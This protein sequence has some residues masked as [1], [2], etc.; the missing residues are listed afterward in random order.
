MASRPKILN[1]L[2]S[3]VVWLLFVLL[4]LLWLPLTALVWLFDR[5]PA[6]Y[7]T[8]RFFRWLAHPIAVLGPSWRARVEGVEIQNPRRPY[9]V[10]A[11][12]QSIL[13][14]PMLALIPMEYKWVAKEPLFRIPV[15]GWMMRLAGDIPLDRAS[16]RSGIQALKAARTY[17]DRKCSV[18]FFPEGTR[19]EDRRVY[20][21]NEGAF[22][23]AVKAQVP[24][25]PMAIEG[26]SDCLP[27]HSWIFG[28]LHDIKIQVLPPV[29]TSGMSK[30][31]V[32]QL[33]RQV[34][35]A[36]IRQIAS[37]QGVAV[38]QVDAAGV[39]RPPAF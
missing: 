24:V 28:D 8:G 31:D 36:I 34:R 21:F 20:D 25:L 37:W 35:A 1:A 33:T 29:E 12:H 5:D 7:R 14:I 9:V 38:E 32:P 6:R 23:L 39:V 18:F 27:K 2:L 17:L 15:L 16:T 4:I 13:D 26:A 22:F 10:V 11:N 3:A 19:S 30:E